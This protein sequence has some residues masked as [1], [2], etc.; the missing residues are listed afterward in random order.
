MTPNEAAMKLSLHMMQ[1]GMLMPPE[2]LA[3]NGEG[4]ELDQAV[5]MALD[6]LRAQPD[7]A[8]PKTNAQAIRAMTDEQL[9]TALLRFAGIGEQIDFCLYKPECEE[10]LDT[11]DDIPD[12]WCHA[13]MLR[14]L[15]TP[16]KA[17]VPNG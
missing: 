3:K 6:L 5:R 2:W 1:C 4:S 15:R 12:E 7:P 14:W 16:E 17:G 13:C 10:R 11:N 8:A 9:A